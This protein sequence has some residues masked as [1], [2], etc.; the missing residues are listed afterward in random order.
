MSRC[1]C[2]P[3]RVGCTADR[4]STVCLKLESGLLS[5]SQALDPRQSGSV[6]TE[7]CCQRTK[8]VKILE[9]SS[10]CFSPRWLRAQPV[11]PLPQRT[12]ISRARSGRSFLKIFLA[13]AGHFCFAGSLWRLYETNPPCRECRA[14][15]G[16][17]RCRHQRA[18]GAWKSRYERSTSCR[19]KQSAFARPGLSPTARLQPRNSAIPKQRDAVHT[20]KTKAKSIVR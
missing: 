3:R 9:L 20:I 6:R 14:P 19:E 4:A 12:P 2:L 8:L 7:C 1:R 16:T 13:S 15:W 10:C 5:L 18:R 17:L 11:V